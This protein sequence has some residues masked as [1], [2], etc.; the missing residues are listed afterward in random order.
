MHRATAS[1]WLSNAWLLTRLN[2]ASGTVRPRRHRQ[3]SRRT[4]V[5]FAKL[6]NELSG[7]KVHAMGAKAAGQI[8]SV[9]AGGVLLALM[10]AGGH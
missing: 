2:D 7:G 9:M 6:L 5:L 3:I 8:A 1:R 4:R 10:G